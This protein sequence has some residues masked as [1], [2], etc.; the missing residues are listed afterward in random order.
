MQ[1]YRETLSQQEKERKKKKE[2][3]LKA[4]CTVFSP[5]SYVFDF[6]LFTV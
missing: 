2:G 1:L 6:Y 3:S 4:F 5:G